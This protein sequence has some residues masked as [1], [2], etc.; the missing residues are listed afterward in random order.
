MSERPQLGCHVAEWMLPQDT[1]E[2]LVKMHDLAS[3]MIAEKAPVRDLRTAYRHYT[4]YLSHIGMMPEGYASAS[5]KVMQESRS[6]RV[7]ALFHRVNCQSIRFLAG[8]GSCEEPCCCR[9]NGAYPNIECTADMTRQIA[10]IHA[11]ECGAWVERA[12]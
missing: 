3:G 12:D 5:V 1:R 9:C 7:R 4:R 10:Y 2:A 6:A 11:Q 8:M